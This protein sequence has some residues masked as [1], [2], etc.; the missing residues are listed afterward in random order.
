ML[1]WTLEHRAECSP[2][3]L[4]YVG[5]VDSWLAYWVAPPRVGE[6]CVLFSGQPVFGGIRGNQGEEWWLPESYVLSQQQQ[7]RHDSL[8][9]CGLPFTVTPGP[10]WANITHLGDAQKPWRWQLPFAHTGSAE[11]SSE[12]GCL[13]TRMWP[14]YA[15]D[16]FGLLLIG[17]GDFASASLLSTPHTVSHHFCLRSQ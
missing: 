2:S 5:G 17:P 3:A 13:A 9:C 15:W 4:P 14:A 16:Q 10:L 11:H 8:L 7:Q 12:S 6:E 1:E